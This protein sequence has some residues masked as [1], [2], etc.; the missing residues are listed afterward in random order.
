LGSDERFALNKDRCTNR[1]ELISLLEGLFKQKSSEEWLVILETAGVP[2]SPINTINQLVDNPQ[3]KALEI[4]QASPDGN[5]SVL[6]LPLSF[7]AVRP[8]FRAPA[9]KL[10][11]HTHEVFASIRARPVSGSAT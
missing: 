7:D 10:G 9:P 3:T 8:P 5:G 1:L 11:E 6:G 2:A 4:L